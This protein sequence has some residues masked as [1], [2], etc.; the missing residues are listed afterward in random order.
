METITKTIDA[1]TTTLLSDLEK[2]LEYNPETYKGCSSPKE[3]D[4]SQSQI[5]DIEKKRVSQFTK[6]NVWAAKAVKNVNS[7]WGYDYTFLKKVNNNKNI[8]LEGL[9]VGDVIKVN[10]EQYG[11]NKYFTKATAFLKITNLSDTEIAL[12]KVVL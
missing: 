11:S 4:F 8:S 10:I 9:K 6:F 3:G 2:S 5:L 1:G 7:K 12:E